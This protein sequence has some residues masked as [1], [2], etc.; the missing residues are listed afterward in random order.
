M[1]ST[2]CMARFGFELSITEAH[3][4]DRKDSPRRERVRER[5]R[6]RERGGEGV[7]TEA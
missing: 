1:T 2:V 6:E 3:R 7:V 4:E 5:K